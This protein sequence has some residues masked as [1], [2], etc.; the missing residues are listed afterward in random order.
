VETRKS[1]RIACPSCDVEI[2]AD[3]PAVIDAERQPELAAR[4]HDYTLP[5]VP[6]P[7]CGVAFRVDAP[8]LFLDGRH[9]LAVETVPARDLGDWQAIEQ[10]LLAFE[11]RRPLP[12]AERFSRRRLVFGLR[13]L[14]EKLF[15]AAHG[16]DDVR[17]E[18]LKLAVLSM[19]PEVAERLTGT[20]PELLLEGLA[21][22]DLVFLV[23]TRDAAGK[24]HQ[25][26]LPL[27]RKLYDGM[28][29][30]SEFAAGFADLADA[31]FVSWLRYVEMK[32]P[33]EATGAQG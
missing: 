27:P 33:D 29:R 31:R 18:L 13:Q 16:F 6:C 9:E 19:H 2:E 11:A 7:S 5:R 20:F 12:D 25:A 24:V 26:Q 28:E 15:L 22:N 1:V 10:R 17:I 30:D 8:F 14:N 32:R 3:L 23:L 21:G 4:V